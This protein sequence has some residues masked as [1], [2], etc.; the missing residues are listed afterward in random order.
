MLTDNQI[1]FSTYSCFNPST[2]ICQAVHVMRM[3]HPGYNLPFPTTAP[4]INL[5]KSYFRIQI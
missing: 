4:I 2:I 1:S 5:F 3:L